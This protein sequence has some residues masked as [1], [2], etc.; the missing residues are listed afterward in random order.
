MRSVIL[1]FCITLL[2]FTSYSQQGTPEEQPINQTDK[3]NRKQGF[4]Y[5]HH[6]PR[7]GEFG[8]TEFGNYQDNRKTGLWYT[9][10][11]IGRIKSIENFRKGVLHGTSRYFEKGNLVLEGNFR[12]LNPDYKFD[13][14]MVVDPETRLDTLVIVNSERGSLKHGTWKYFDPI[15]GTLLKVEEYQVGELIREKKYVYNAAADSVY[16]EKIRN[17]MPHVRDPDGRRNNRN[18]HRGSLIR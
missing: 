8:F 7:M 3:K 10:D 11:E 5:L 1:I 14:I 13:S 2:S 9:M 17:E 16:K 15:Y 12:G 18:N 4:W 6:P